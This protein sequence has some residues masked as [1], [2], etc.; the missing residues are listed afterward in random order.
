MSAACSPCW[1]LLRN[2]AFRLKRVLAPCLRS[3]RTANLLAPPRGGI[4]AEAA[5][6]QRGYTA[7]P[8]ADTKS[9][10]RTDAD[11]RFT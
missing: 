5:R 9:V 7:P 3:D 6:D 4:T 2:A 8:S 1:V 11:I 10:Y